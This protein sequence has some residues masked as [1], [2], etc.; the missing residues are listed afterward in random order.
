MP[1]EFRERDEEEQRSGNNFFGVIR[2]IQML[3]CLACA[4][5]HV[6]SYV[7]QPNPFPHVTLFCG[8]FCG[9]FFV[10]TALFVAYCT[11]S[12]VSSHVEAACSLVSGLLCSTCGIVAMVFVQTY[13]YLQ[14]SPSHPLHVDYTFF[15]FARAQS[16]MSTV[17]ALCFWIDFFLA[18]DMWLSLRRPSPDARRGLGMFIERGEIPRFRFVCLDLYNWA[19]TLRCRWKTPRLL[20]RTMQLHGVEFETEEFVRLYYQK[21]SREQEQQEPA[22]GSQPSGKAAEEDDTRKTPRAKKVTISM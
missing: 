20:Q 16:V 19:R 9:S 4:V 15:H 11:E 6:L 13:A 1:V 22:G 7:D 10:S 17:T 21:L 2:F 8:T 12:L 3:L 14:H 18:F 5:V